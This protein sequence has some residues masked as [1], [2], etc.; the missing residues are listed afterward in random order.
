VTLR[1][2]FYYHEGDNP[3]R[4]KNR[5]DELQQ[6]LLPPNCYVFVSGNTAAKHCQ[7]LFT[8]QTLNFGTIN[9]TEQVLH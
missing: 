6:S 7:T 1:V 4:I 8:L 5:L 2:L 9:A 3:A